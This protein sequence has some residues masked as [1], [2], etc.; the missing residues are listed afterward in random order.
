MPWRYDRRFDGRPERKQSKACPS[1]HR[2]QPAAM[3]VLGFSREADMTRRLLR[4]AA[5]LGGDGWASYLEFVGPQGIPDV[6]FARFSVSATEAREGSPLAAAFVERREAAVLL[7]LHQSRPL[8]VEDVATRAKL[9]AGTVRSVLRAFESSGVAAASRG[10]WVRVGPAPS[11]LA[12]A[13]AI[14]LKLGDWQR[15]LGQA[16]R[17]RGFAERSY[18]VVAEEH[19]RRAAAQSA[20]FRLNG[21]GLAALSPWGSLDF[22]V[23]PRTRRPLDAV[24][25]FLAGERLWAAHQQQSQVRVTEAA[26]A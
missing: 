9:A 16:A 19:A 1:D 25:R 6:V 21:V 5:A 17:Y 24:A 20:A 7:S 26:V 13:V 15:A 23:R 10:R 8:S 2:L 18:V 3:V 14:E 22:M 4:Q 11:R 12:A